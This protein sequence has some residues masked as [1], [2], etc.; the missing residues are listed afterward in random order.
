MV[1]V[2]IN[3]FFGSL[4]VLSF[5]IMNQFILMHHAICFINVIV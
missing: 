2:V 1:W 3:I 5:F 4:S